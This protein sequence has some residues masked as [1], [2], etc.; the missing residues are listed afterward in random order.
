[1]AKFEYQPAL[2]GVRALAVA[3]VLGFH[4]D[5]SWM[6]GGYLGVSV[7]FTLSGF[8]I[9][10]LLLVEH[11][12][13]GYVDLPGFYQ[14]RA[15][16]LVPAGLFVLALVCV[17]VATKLIDAPSTFRRQVIGAVLQVLNWV[18]LFSKQSYADLF[19]AP[20]PIVHYWSLGIE[21]QF[22]VIW[23]LLLVVILRLLRR[24]AAPERLLAVTSG[25]W[26]ICAVSA[27]LTARWWSNDAAY[28]A[29]WARAPEVLSGAVLAVLLSR[30][31]LP[32]WCAWL[33]PL[34]V[35]GMAV[36][37]VVTPAGH[38]WAF[39]G[40]LPLFSLLSLLLVAGLQVP[41][42]VTRALSFRPLV[43]VGGISYGLY[44][45][46]WPLFQL[47]DEDRTGLHGVALAAVRLAVTFA[48]ATVSYYALEHPIRTRQVL[49]S[50]RALTATLA[51][52]VMVVA[53]LAFSVD[54]PVAQE[55]GGPTIITAATT[56][57]PATTSGGGST[58]STGGASTTT[59][60]PTVMAVFGDSV[61]A[62]L[63]RDGA[64]GFTH[65]DVVLVN[66]TIP[67]C[68]GVVNMPP[69]RS[70]L[71][72]IV[73]V[74]AD[75]Q[76]WDTWYPKVLDEKAAEVGAPVTVALLVVGTKAALDRQ[77]DGG[78]TGPCDT[79]DWYVSDIEA[80]VDWLRSRGITPVFAMPP[81]LGGKSLFIMPRD[82]PQRV[83]CERAALQQMVER[84]HVLTVDLDPELCP[85][86]DCD[87]IR[88]NDGIHVDPPYAAE[89][90]NWLVG[91]ALRLVR[92]G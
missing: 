54:V 29:T 60:P 19:R 86:D 61:P 43:W 26:A 10:S 84:D 11:G 7:F 62:W 18:Q 51:G 87:A 3:A 30:R 92:S 55:A 8:L 12:Q 70:G 42:P 35:G 16:R 91:E 17:G 49:P 32:R 67:G 56:V 77:V 21:E 58:P 44:L 36:L 31:T 59:P 47:L 71:G 65:S 34:A 79:L 45:F 81:R 48:A 4:L 20:S 85:N 80:R 15:R 22:Y 68:D 24:Y 90:L 82:H 64:A 72:N 89:V 78:W 39:A 14:R 2:D 41:S 73:D 33:A 38:G 25:L 74:P 52:A 50:V 28:Y 40:G 76:P 27:P 57:P 5:V 23:P 75:C 9:T 6:T 63:I 69:V 1:M 88:N 46:H 66:G 37:V 53:V 83:A 13:K